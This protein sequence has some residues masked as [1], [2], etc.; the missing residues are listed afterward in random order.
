MFKHFLFETSGAGPIVLA[1]L[2]T[3]VTLGAWVLAQRIQMALRTRSVQ[4][5]AALR[6][7]ILTRSSVWAQRIR[8]LVSLLT[9]L[10][11]AV[12]MGLS[13]ALGAV[14]MSRLGAVLGD[15][16]GARESLMADMAASFTDVAQAYL[17]MVGGTIVLVVGPV[18]MFIARPIE[19]AADE[20]AGG[21]PEDR[22]LDEL[23]RIRMALEDSSGRST[24]ST[25]G[26]EDR[27]REAS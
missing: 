9:L 16:G 15:S 20:V 4:P 11:P 12:G 7:E 10:G 2:L 25:M 23:V 21:E 1:M 13:T 6:L 14:G 22:L 27:M 18:I 5:E 3:Q 26:A 17:V 24:R 19:T 8:P